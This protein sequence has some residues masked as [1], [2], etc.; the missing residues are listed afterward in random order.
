MVMHA[1]FW[2][3]G[4]YIGIGRGVAMPNH[5]NSG[6]G[7]RCGDGTRWNLLGMTRHVY[8]F[9]KKQAQAEADESRPDGEDAGRSNG[10][11]KLDGEDAGLWAKAKGIVQHQYALTPLSWACSLNEHSMQGRAMTPDDFDW[12]WGFPDVEHAPL[13]RLVGYGWFCG[14]RYDLNAST[15]DPR[16]ESEGLMDIVYAQTNLNAFGGACGP[17]ILD[18]GTGSGCLLIQLLLHYPSAFGIGVDYSADALRMA[19][20]NATRHG[21]A[22]RARWMVGDG[23]EVL[24]GLG[25]DAGTNREEHG[26]VRCGEVF[27]G[28]N[29]VGSSSFDIIISNPPYVPTGY[30]APKNVAL[31]DP[32]RALYAGVDGFRFYRAWIGPMVRCLAP[33]GILVLE[34]GY[35]QGPAVWNLCQ[36]AGLSQIHILPDHDGK[37]RYVWGRLR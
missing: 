2:Y 36:H 16:W 26:E 19:G 21:V 7:G 28:R 12:L 4:Y 33:R 20:K 37:D 32:D 3:G 30:V 5:G 35:D 23:A 1:G 8:D 14:R 18:M 17:R 10:G 15:L 31:W 25:G 13:S 9:L 34:I 24:M 22:E 29:L 11:G 6:V 27:G